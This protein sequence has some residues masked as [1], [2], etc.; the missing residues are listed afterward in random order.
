MMTARDV[1]VFINKYESLGLDIWFNGG[2]GVDALLG[3][4]TRP[5][6]DVDIF[7]EAQDALKL[8]GL[9]EVEG[10]KEIK[11][12]IARPFNYV[13]GDA[14]SHE[15]DIHVI[16]YDGKGCIIYGPIENGEIYPP[17]L[18]SGTGV[19]SGRAVKCISPEWMVKWHTGY[20][21][22]EHDFKD[23]SAL[24]EKFGIELP[25]EYRGF[26]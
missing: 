21:P 22:R 2:W 19:I 18:F 11:L 23:V 8:R 13:L 15:I 5:H 4:Q 12:E 14:A 26:T 16:T 7:I 24:C 17:D 3:K 10:Y 25:E 20:K 1:V 6:N 9:L